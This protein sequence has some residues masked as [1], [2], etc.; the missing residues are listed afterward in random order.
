MLEY[1]RN[2]DKFEA[3]YNNRIVDEI[4]KRVE[5]QEGSRLITNSEIKKLEDLINYDDSFI[6]SMLSNEVTRATEKEGNLLTSINKV[7]SDLSTFI[8]GDPDADNVINRWQEVVQF[9]SSITEDKD[10]ASLL[11]ELKNE[12][13]QNVTDK[14]STYYNSN[15]ID[16]HFL[17]KVEGSRLIT[18]EEADKLQSITNY[19]DAE[20]RE[21]INKEAN[22]A[23]LEEQNIREE[24]RIPTIIE[25]GSWTT[26]DVQELSP[27]VF[28]IFR[29]FLATNPTATLS[30]NLKTPP[31]SSKYNEYMFQLETFFPV[32]LVLPSTIMWMNE[33]IIEIGHI[34]HVSIVNNI[35]VIG[36]V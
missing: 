27:N 12:V 17:K 1:K 8:T 26:G 2:G 6:K 25:T 31:I 36:G 34:Y 18:S 30:I 4:H 20:I 7:A 19:D 16:S 9:L 15:Y 21:L 24:F 32:T 11:L 29:Q 13:N 33:P 14:L 35:A 22:R 10:L 23:V 5:K 3:E 28:Y